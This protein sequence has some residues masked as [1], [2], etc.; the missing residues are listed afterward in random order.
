[1][2]KDSTIENE[3]F[4]EIPTSIKE[5]EDIKKKVTDN[6]D[7]LF[8]LLVNETNNQLPTWSTHNIEKLYKEA[9]EENKSVINPKVAMFLLENMFDIELDDFQKYILFSL[10]SADTEMTA[11]KEKEDTKVV[12]QYNAIRRRNKNDE[13]FYPDLHLNPPGIG[14]MPKFRVKPF[15]TTIYQGQDVCSNKE[16]NDWLIEHKDKVAKHYDSEISNENNENTENNNSE[17]NENSSELTRH[18]LDIYEEVKVQLEKEKERTLKFNQ[19][20][21]IIPRRNGKSYLLAAY[22]LLRIIVGAGVAYTSISEGSA[23]EFSGLIQDIVR[24]SKFSKFFKFPAQNSIE[25]LIF[26]NPLTGEE[27][28]LLVS[29][30][31]TEG[32]RGFGRGIS[33][34]IFDESQHLSKK[35]IASLTPLVAN[36]PDEGH[37]SSQILYVGT[38]SVELSS[39]SDGSFREIV[40]SVKNEHNSNCLHVEWSS[41]K[42]VKTVEEASDIKVLARFNPAMKYNYSSDKIEKNSRLRKNSFTYSNLHTF[43]VERL[44]YGGI[45]NKNEENTYISYDVLKGQV[46][47]NNELDEIAGN[48]PTYVLGIGANKKGYVSISLIASSSYNSEAPYYVDNIFVGDKN[49]EDFIDNIE[50]VL[51]L[52]SYQPRCKFIS[53]D[54]DVES[55]VKP[56]LIKL[57]LI[58]DNSIN[59]RRRGKSKTKV[60]FYAD[61][62][63]KLSKSVLETIVNSKRVFFSSNNKFLYTLSSVELDSNNTNYVS[64][65]GFASAVVSSVAIGLYRHLNWWKIEQHNM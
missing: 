26:K 33:V 21:I 60:I 65:L 18:E 5:V 25:K 2:L 19:A 54:K 32:L 4:L 29:T 22:S 15:A 37:L 63:N 45:D 57:G 36:A 28:K 38:P 12:Y 56:I 58:N 51:E 6:N 46:L 9:V 30:R 47:S 43:S 49:K 48:N 7:V 62:D 31:N 10:L 52:Y 13:E 17:N 50:K 35:H 40:E 11:R 16:V 23:R 24:N 42:R 14:I 64:T 59:Q 53:C 20:S 3:N 41:P 1:M 8:Q 34:I 44:G 39:G 55:I 27:S 61:K